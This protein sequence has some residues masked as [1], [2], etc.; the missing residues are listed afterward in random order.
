MM[1]SKLALLAFACTSSV[2][3][4]AITS[5][6]PCKGARASATSLRWK[7][8]VDSVEKML[9]EEQKGGPYKDAYAPT[10]SLFDNPGCPRANTEYKGKMSGTLDDEVLI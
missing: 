10:I 4:F 6:L 8:N 3:A 2:N 7:M 1:L 5:T 9:T